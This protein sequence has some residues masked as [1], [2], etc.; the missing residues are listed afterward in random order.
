MSKINHSKPTY[1]TRQLL[2]QRKETEKYIAAICDYKYK[3]LPA[4]KTLV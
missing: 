2:D 1:S 3:D 4:T